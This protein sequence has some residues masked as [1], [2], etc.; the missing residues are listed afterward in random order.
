MKDNPISK[1]AERMYGKTQSSRKLTAYVKHIIASDEF[2]EKV[3]NIRKKYNMPPKGFRVEKDNI[4]NAP[5][6]FKFDFK[7]CTEEVDKM[8]Q[9]Y[10]LHIVEWETTFR[11]YIYYNRFVEPYDFA[12]GHLCH[13]SDLIEEKEDPF[14]EKI[15]AADDNIYPIAIRISPYATKRDIIDYVEKGYGWINFFQQRHR[16]TKSLIGVIKQK[17][18]LI[19]KRNNFIL[20]FKHLPLKEI[21]LKLQETFN[22]DIDEGHI[23]KII[24]LEKKRRRKV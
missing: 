10:N 13:M 12:L 5:S 15:Q 21:A 8:C 20:K 24:S 17:N 9:R 6:T 11:G 14:S 3:T 2:Q 1:I 23:S 18:P 4:L 22:L 16:D 19:V 7:L